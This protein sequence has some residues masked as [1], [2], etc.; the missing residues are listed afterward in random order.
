M[1]EKAPDYTVEWH[2]V[3]KAAN[4]RAVYDSLVEMLA[5][6]G[7]VGEDP[8]KTCI[9]LVNR[10]ALGGFYPRKD[11]VLLEFKTDYAIDDPLILKTEQVSRS[12][13]HHRIRLDSPADLSGRAA[14]WLRDAYI[15]SG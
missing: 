11:Y 9:H 6:Y 8:K 3:G 4:V 14:T 5:E 7:A 15:L 1:Q 10:T 12:R 13:F 2:F